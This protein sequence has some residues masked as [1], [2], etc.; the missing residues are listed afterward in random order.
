MLISF[1]ILNKKLLIPF[2]FPLFIKL[3]R[4]IR[5]E[6]YKILKNPFFKIFN[7][8]LS[9]TICGL[10]Y[11][12]VL[13]RLKKEKE[14][15]N[16]KYT[17]NKINDSN[18]AVLIVQK[19]FKEDKDII[20]LNLK[21]DDN[22]NNLLQEEEKKFKKNEYKQKLYFMMLLSL[23]QLIPLCIKDIWIKSIYI[24]LDYRQTI[25]VFFELIL[26]ILFSIIF[27]N[28]QIYK[29]Q[30]FSLLII[31]LCLFIFFAGTIIANNDNITCVLKHIC[32]FLSTQFFF[33]LNNVLGKK[34]LNL[35]F[36]NIYLFMS[37]MGFFGLIPMLLNDI[38]VE[39]FFNDSDA[40]YHGIIIYFRLLFKTPK[41]IYLFLLDLLFGAFYQIGLWLTI[42]YFSPLHFII[43]E[44]MGEFVETTFNIIKPEWQDKE[45]YKK[46]LVILYY[47][48]YPL[49]IFSVLTFNE[50]IIL[51]FCELDYNTKKGIMLRQKI[52][53]AYNSSENTRESDGIQNSLMSD[54]KSDED[55]G[56]FY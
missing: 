52:D 14:D 15:E 30:V 3:R 47:I 22:D 26:L 41:Y 42:Y 9:F 44:V 35:Y 51:N 25:A 39:L 12:I 2:I 45:K 49:V 29:H 21:D 18:N 13:Y 54:E 55:N 48:F 40:K 8:F 28:S 16:E 32:Y 11:L 33:C 36:D 19:S 50:I 20:S 10:I 23:L 38:F 46:G 1:G 37:K 34:Y 27:L 56:I 7:T 17:I 4:F 43:L 24:N 6:E 5:D 53:C 31:I